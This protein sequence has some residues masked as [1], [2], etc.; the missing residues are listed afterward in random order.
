MWGTLH[1][2]GR[3]A[4]QGGAFC[5]ICI[6]QAKTQNANYVK[7]MIIDVKTLHYQWVT[8]FVYD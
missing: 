2:T 3:S 6:A 1:L 8:G 5:A 7:F 4:T